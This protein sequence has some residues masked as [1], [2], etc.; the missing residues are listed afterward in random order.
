MST[1]FT[2]IHG[3]QRMNLIDSD[4]DI[5]ST[6]ISWFTVLVFSEI[7][8]HLDN[9]WMDCFE[10]NSN[11]DSHVNAKMMTPNDFSD[12]LMTKYLQN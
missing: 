2:N 10:S 11:T 5:T 7:E 3:P 6:T 1:F 4:P 12:P 9:Y 8:N